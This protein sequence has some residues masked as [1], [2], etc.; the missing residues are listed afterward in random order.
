MRIWKFWEI[1]I[2]RISPVFLMGVL[3]CFA[4]PV[5]TAHAEE[6]C[7][8]LTADGSNATDY[9]PSFSPDGKRVLFSRSFDHGK[10]WNLYVVPVSGGSATPLSGNAL[11]VSA[12]RAS[13]SQKRNLVAFTGISADHRAALWIING[14]G[15]GAHEVTV[16]GLSPKVFYPSWLPDGNKLVVVDFGNG[17]GGV[18][19]LVNLPDNTSIPLTN[20]NEILCGMPSA[21]PNGNWIAFAGQRNEGQRYDQRNNRILCRDSAGK[22]T[23]LTSRQGRTPHWSPDGTKLVFESNFGSSDG[24]YAAFLVIPGKTGLLQLTP[25]SWNAN[26]P[27]WSPDGTLLTFSARSAKNTSHIA[28]LNFPPETK[29]TIE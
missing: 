7:R 21:A 6:A 29:N 13:W 8:F 2:M 3:C 17:N 11:P 12:T 1:R 26:H 19:K 5:M 25:F 23:A 10:T 18:L 15:T 14:D 9:W 24:N 16:S 27:E 28:I 20:Q 4:A 22:I